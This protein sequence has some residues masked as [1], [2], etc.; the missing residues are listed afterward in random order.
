MAAT[1][2]EDEMKELVGYLGNIREFEQKHHYSELSL[3]SAIWGILMILAGIM[4]FHVSLYAGASPHFF[5]WVGFVSAGFISQKIISTQ[6]LIYDLKTDIERYDVRSLDITITA[7]I[8]LGSL[9]VA[10]LNFN[11]IIPYIAIAL[12]SL[13][14]YSGRKDKSK[15]FWK[16][17]EAGL[18]YYLVAIIIV[19][20]GLIR[21]ELFILQGLIF[22]INIG[23]R[24]LLQSYFQRRN[25]LSYTN[26]NSEISETMDDN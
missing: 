6:P 13:H 15:S 7:I 11:Y 20:L 23:M 8:F 25:L 9:V 12:G 17:Y 10:V 3:T 24:G 2:K 19:T 5:V 22:G 18:H 4:D 21:E 16:R 14:F 1:L 26:D